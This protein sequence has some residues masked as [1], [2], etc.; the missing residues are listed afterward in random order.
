M[1][2]TLLKSAL[3]A[4]ATVGMLAGNSYALPYL[5]GDIDFAGQLK[6]LD[7]TGAATNNFLNT[8]GFSFEF[9]SVTGASGDFAELAPIY[10][11]SADPVLTYGEANPFT[12]DPFPSFPLEIWTIESDTS[13]KIFSF[14]LSSANLKTRGEGQIYLTG[15]GTLTADGYLG[16]PGSWSFTTQKAEDSSLGKVE[17]SYSTGNVANP[18]PEPATILLFGTGLA[19]LAGIARRK[20]K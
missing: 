13:N 20:K 11:T 1:K 12:F 7:S 5:N 8:V 6:T 17:F 15:N 14:S 4:L 19:G 9:L 18:V 16:T 3:M 10:S 2:K